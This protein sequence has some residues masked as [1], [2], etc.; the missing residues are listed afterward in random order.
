[1]DVRP[2]TIA[3]LEQAAEESG[4]LDYMGSR[5]QDLVTDQNR[6]QVEPFIIALGYLFV[7]QGDVESR[8]RSEEA[9]GA[10]ME[11]D[12]QRFPP[13]LQDLDEGA[14]E[15]WE[16]AL[17][18]VEHPALV[19]RFHDLLWVMRR[20]ERPDLH[21]RAAADA[22]L[23]LA[24]QAGWPPV[25]R[26]DALSRALELSR[27]V[28]DS[29]RGEHL[30]AAIVATVDTHLEQENGDEVGPGAVMTLLR[31]LQTSGATDLEVLDRLLLATDSHYEGD[32]HVG[33]GVADMREQHLDPEAR[34]TMRT[35]Q[36]NR[37]RRVAVNST[38]LARAVHLEHA[39]EIARAHGLKRE[40]DELLR[41]LQEISDEGLELKEFSTE[42][43]IPTD[44]WDAMIAAFIDKEGGWQGS[45]AR[46]GNAG[47]PGG[48][49]AEVNSRVDEL[50]RKAPIQFLVRKVVYGAEGASLF[51][52]VDET[53]HR[54][55]AVAEQR[56]FSARIFALTAVRVLAQIEE[57]Q[58]SPPNSELA[59]YFT[60]ELIPADLASPIA[61]SIELYFQGHYDEA[62][63]ML[64]PRLERVVRE[65]ARRVGLPIIRPPTG[66]RPGGV[67]T[68]GDLLDSLKGAFAEDAWRTYLK[69][70]LTDPLGVNLRNVIA[71]DL[72]EEIGEG[73]VALMIHA[74]CFLRLL[75]ASESGS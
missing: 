51:Q 67:R 58:G 29:E 24:E 12:N 57:K 46:F 52:A 18:A 42:I 1:M 10:A 41:E 73:E 43:Q 70:L 22:Y 61:R 49:D 23:E 14:A 72:Q 50:M 68:M 17:D 55:L 56:A 69:S 21:A 47:P 62:G 35:E 13:T 25:D 59:E 5:L 40:R 19:A 16:D 74:A 6:E 20:G 53:S 38:G 65:L 31:S 36:I 34:Q 54:H 9:F 8:E 44:R 2:E 26:A 3:T 37:W 32:L 15:A 30:R 75:S 66:L 11:F 63:H 60:T 45:L 28:G 48:S 39:L 27:A 71:H 4:G 7:E 64:A 33:D